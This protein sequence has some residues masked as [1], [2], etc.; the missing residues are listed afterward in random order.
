MSYLQDIQLQS[1]KKSLSNRI[2]L[3]K[4]DPTTVLGQ[5][6]MD[7]EN[8][9]PI[10][11]ILEKARTG[12]YAD[13]SYNRK[14][15][16]VGKP[17]KKQSK[18][19]EEK[20]ESEKETD[21]DWKPKKIFEITSGAKYGYVGADNPE[22][23]KELFSKITGEDVSSSRVKGS[24]KY[25]DSLR[26]NKDMN[27]Q[28]GEYKVTP[29]SESSEKQE[30]TPDD[31]LDKINSLPKKKIAPGGGEYSSN[32]EEGKYNEKIKKKEE[33]LRSQYEKAKKQK[34]NQDLYKS[35]SKYTDEQRKKN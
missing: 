26:D 19:E 21:K 17:Y 11:E 1:L 35:Q 32:S 34:N 20:K 2:N 10:E 13:N 28:G 27:F 5:A 30:E 8:G 29:N 12:Y 23:A 25:S 3:E 33:K 9:V 18:Q 16:L 14:H 15:G 22:Q 4:A 31:I 24:S 6:A 7:A